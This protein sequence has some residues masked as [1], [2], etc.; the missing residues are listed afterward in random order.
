ALPHLAHV[1]AVLNKPFI[2][3]E[4]TE[5]ATVAQK[6]CL[7]FTDAVVT[8]D[9]YM[10]DFGKK[11]VRFNGY[12][13]L[14]YLHP[15]YFKPDPSV[16]D[17]LGLRRDDNFIILRFVSWGAT[18]DI[19]Q[20]GIKNKMELVRKLDKYGRVLITSEGVLNTKLEK[21]KIKISP[22]KLH[23]LL[24]YAS[25]YIGEGGTMATESAVLGTHAIH[26]ST[27]AK[28]CGIFYDLNKYDLMWISDAENGAIGKVVEILQKNNIKKE[29]KRKR[30]KL[31][32]DKIDVTAFMIKF[33][34][35][36]PESLKIMKKNPN[37]QDRFRLRR[38]L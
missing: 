33:M 24:Y 17:D 9:C 35:I 1:S 32:K 30:E 10:R 4:D 19:C 22:E 26:I 6:I 16:L 7:P 13:E 31:L 36:Y 20:H 27:T 11:H 5:H 18:H 12:Y 3:F 25:L 15:N 28:Y 14:A 38:S 34:E 23:D 37:Y 21:Y 29:G 8:P 2:I